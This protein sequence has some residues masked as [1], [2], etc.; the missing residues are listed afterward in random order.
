VETLPCLSQTF[1]LDGRFG[2]K[3]FENEN[4]SR[5]GLDPVSFGFKL[6]HERIV[7]FGKKLEVISYLNWEHDFGGAMGN[8][9]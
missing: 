5:Q 7:R 8:S 9:Y 3:H 6:G 2:R 1:S 4:P